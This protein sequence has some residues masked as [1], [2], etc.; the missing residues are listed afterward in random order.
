M[1]KIIPVQCQKFYNRENARC[2]EYIQQ[3]NLTYFRRS[4]T[5]RKLHYDKCYNGKS[6]LCLEIPQIR[7][8]LSLWG[9]RESSSLEKTLELALVAQMQVSDS[10]AGRT[11]LANGMI[12]RMSQSIS[13]SLIFSSSVLLGQCGANG[14]GQWY[15]WGEQEMRLNCSSEEFL[16][17]RVG[18]L[19]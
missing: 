16:C 12:Y 10:R 5:V 6:F 7:K 17:Q 11:F 18:T 15:M 13:Q 8:C 4:G 3:K 2:Y 19:S 14:S 9:V 1:V